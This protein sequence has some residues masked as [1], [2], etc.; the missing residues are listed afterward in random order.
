MLKKQ[1]NKKN[2]GFTI[3][4]VMIVLAIAGL[5]L[6]VVFLA[7]P[8]LQRNARNTSRKTD[9]QAILAGVSEYADNNDG[10]LPA[11]IAEAGT[12]PVQVTFGTVGTNTIS[13]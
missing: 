9:V 3:I 7:V 2:Q 5:I 8:A 1:V 12:N 10:T 11:A 13:Q 6:L 4:E